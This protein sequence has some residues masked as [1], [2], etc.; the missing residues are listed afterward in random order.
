MGTLPFWDTLRARGAF[1][2]ALR[3]INAAVVGLLLVAVFLAVAIAPAVNALDRRRVG[4]AL[5]QEFSDSRVYTVATTPPPADWSSPA[6][7]H[8]SVD[9]PDPL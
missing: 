5:A 8:A 6:S 9:L 3:G 4:V 7:T 1:Q 2:G